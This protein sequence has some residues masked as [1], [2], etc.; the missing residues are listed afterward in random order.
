MQFCLSWCVSCSVAAEWLIAPVVLIFESHIVSINDVSF[1]VS[2]ISAAFLTLVFAFVLQ[3]QHALSKGR[4]RGKEA[5]VCLPTMRLRR[6]GKDS[7]GFQAR[8]CQKRTVSFHA[9]FALA[10][11][12]FTLSYES[13]CRRVM[14]VFPLFCVLCRDELAK[15][16]SDVID[17]PSLT[18]STD[19]VC[20]ECDH[21]G[22]VMMQGKPLPTDEKI[23]LIFVCL[24]RDCCHK[25]QE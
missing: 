15:I 12:D 18:R 16:P 6:R 9:F 13:H 20:P 23:K 4:P 24:N 14:A 11:R 2:S 1:C 21:V 3:P 7:S 19:I 8:T 25:W 22:G 5:D 10:L 17:D